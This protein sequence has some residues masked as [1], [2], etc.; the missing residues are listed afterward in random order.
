MYLTAG[1]GRVIIVAS[2][3]W[4]RPGTAGPAASRVGGPAG[5]T[6]IGSSAHGRADKPREHDDLDIA[7]QLVSDRRIDVE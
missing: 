4:P 5:L 6:E 1:G 7:D 2:C 3:P